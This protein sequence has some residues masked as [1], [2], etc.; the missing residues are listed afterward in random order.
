MRVTNLFSI[1]AALVLLT[2][3][4]IFSQSDTS[5]TSL[6]VDSSGIK[7]AVQSMDVLS[8]TPTVNEISNLYLLATKGERDPFRIVSLVASKGDNAI[9]ALDGFLFQTNPS[10]QN[11]TPGIIQVLPN[12]QYALYALD[13]IGTLKAEQLLMKVAQS[14]LDNDIRGLALKTL[15]Y[16]IYFRTKN[17]ETSK[18]SSGLKPDKELLHVLLQNADDTT[19]AP[20]LN[21][22]I[23]KIAREGINNWTG[24]D[25]GD[26]PKTPVKIKAFNN[27]EMNIKDYREQWWKNN[28]S[29]I[30]WN[31]NTDHFEMK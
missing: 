22:T 23:G 19:Y 12:K 1:A 7:A 16:N 18:N 31:K 9:P 24:E 27:Q 25:Y 15:S 5:D 29:K 11:A 17:D 13:A 26:L 20:N 6:P 3:T 2:T 30:S 14:N 8:S 21:E 4:I 28:N 10:T